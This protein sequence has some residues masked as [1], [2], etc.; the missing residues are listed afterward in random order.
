[1]SLCQPEISGMG[2]YR[3]DVLLSPIHQCQSTEGNTKPLA[4]T[5]P[6]STTRLLMGCCCLY[7]GSLMQVPM[8]C[9]THTLN[10]FMA[11]LPRLSG[12]AGARR[13]LDFYGAT[14]RGDIRGRH[15]D[16]PAGH[17]SIWTNQWPTSRMPFLPQLSKFILGLRRAL[18]ML[19]SESSVNVWH[20]N[21][22]YRLLKGLSCI[23]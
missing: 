2:F 19:E 18:N 23:D 3:P 10:H 14:A 17:H 1:M 4:L 5:H 22:M 7:F 15:T 8:F 20:L 6:S 21:A 13:N 16:N 11:L 9:R 12:W